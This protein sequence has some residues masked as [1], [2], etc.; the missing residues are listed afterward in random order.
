MVENNVKVWIERV[1]IGTGILFLI[2]VLNVI[3]GTIEKDSILL[4]IVMILMAIIILGISTQLTY[5][6]IQEHT[7]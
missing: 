2:G 5:E 3:L 4:T 6:T 7:E 1:W